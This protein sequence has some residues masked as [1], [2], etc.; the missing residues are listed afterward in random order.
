MVA[1]V[2]L[3]G[4]GLQEEPSTPLL[5]LAYIHLLTSFEQPIGRRPKE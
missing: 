2:W 3:A 4:F 5:R 1:C